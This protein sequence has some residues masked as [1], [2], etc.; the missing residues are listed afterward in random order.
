[1]RAMSE[2]SE[3]PHSAAISPSRLGVRRWAQA[4]CTV[5]R[6]T[7]IEAFRGRLLWMTLLGALGV[8]TIAT[9]AHDLALT[10]QRNVGLGFAAP[11][12]RLVAVI[13]IALSAIGSAA[14]EHSDGSLLLA[15]AAPMSRVGWLIG[16]VLAF[17]SLAALTAI[18]LI[19]PLIEYAPAPAAAFAWL[20]SLTMEL[21]LVASVSLAIGIVVTRIPLAVCAFLA[22]Y[23]L[24]RDL[25][26]LQ[27]L[28]MRA[29]RYSQSDA[30]ATLARTATAIFPRLD[31]FTRTDWLFD[32]APD[33]A[34]IAL[35]A[36]QSSMYCLLALSAAALDL[37]RMR[38]G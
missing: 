34:T 25:H 5:A 27:L 32:A 31:L 20:A 11:L 33:I 14:R 15:L 16:K 35:L 12:A 28:A 38:L 36:L 6:D 29:E 13:I 37:R 26:V 24:A 9:F 22:F 18:I 10:E 2:A 4:V 21:A 8:A 17:F 30:L 7:L 23:A 1:M 3:P 19:V